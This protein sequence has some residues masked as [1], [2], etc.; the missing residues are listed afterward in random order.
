[1]NPANSLVCSCVV[2]ARLVG[3]SMD[4]AVSILHRACSI[5]DCLTLL[6]QVALLQRRLIPKDAPIKSVFLPLPLGEGRG[7][8]EN[9][10]SYP[11][12]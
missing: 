7:E 1:M 2:G 12:P 6:Q 3:R 9:S 8:G 11:S 5:A 4:I 10:T